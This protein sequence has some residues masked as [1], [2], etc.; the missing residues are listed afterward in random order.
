MSGD[1]LPR[2]T[3]FVCCGC[4]WWANSVEELAGACVVYSSEIGYCP[5][6]AEL[7]ARERQRAAAVRQLRDGDPI[8][9]FGEGPP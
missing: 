6:N 9:V 5:A 8:R 7:R 2:V 3:G 1:V 4:G